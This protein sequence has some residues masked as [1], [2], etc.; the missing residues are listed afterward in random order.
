MPTLPPNHTGVTR[1]T[2]SAGAATFLTSPIS[3]QNNA[4][5]TIELWCSLDALVD[6]MPMVSKGSEFMLASKG[7]TLYAALGGQTVPLRSQALL[8]TSIPYYVCVIYDGATMSLYLNGALAAQATTNANPPLTSTPLTVGNGFYGEVQGLR[9]WTQAMNA[10]ILGKNQFNDFPAN[11]ALLATQVDFTVSPPVDT[12]GHNLAPT[13]NDNAVYVPF[14]PAAVLVTSSF[15]DPYNDGA[16]NPGGSQQPFSLSAWIRPDIYGSRMYIFTNGV[17][18]SNSGVALGI[19]ADAK[20][21]LQVGNSIVLTS[22]AALAD[23]AWVYVAATW[24]PPATG[25]LYING[26]QDSS[27]TGMTLAGSLV[28]GAPLVGAIASLG[29]KLPINSFDGL[30][31]SVCVWN[32]ALTAQQVVTYKDA[33]PQADPACVAYYDLSQAPAQNQISFNPMGLVAGA[34]LAPNPVYS[35]GGATFARF[36]AAAAAA[37]PAEP[38]P[39][40]DTDEFLVR[41]DAHFAALLDRFDLTEEQRA[42]FQQAHSERLRAGQRDFLAG[43]VADC[44]R[45]RI[46]DLGGGLARMTYVH[47]DGTEEVISDGDF[48]ACTL[49]C[50]QLVVAI[51]GALWLA[52]GLAF[53]YPKFLAGMTTFFGT[54]INTIGI[55]PQLTAAFRNGVTSQGIYTTLK[56]LF[57]YSLLTS[58][59]KLSYQLVFSALSWWTILSLAMRIVLLMSPTAVLEILWLITQLAYSIYSIQQ[60]VAQRPA[61]CLN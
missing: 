26:Q 10:S 23:G 24:S 60:V 6:S 47:P 12:S 36:P 1:F 11:T 9:L 18:E 14:V 20:L 5:W 46:D 39:A 2:T 42:F 31:Q 41:A 55:M 43:L 25:I 28:A 44:A 48:D 32:V 38:L 33:S 30:L 19:G 35:G 22:Q 57:E 4:A 8:A 29:A 56:L 59:A 54:R 61:G 37:V 16:V 49:W 7:A 34:A 15:C 3:F 53:N 58:I 50:I 40:P 27:S 17:Q 13:L 45:V 51:V 52:L 21:F